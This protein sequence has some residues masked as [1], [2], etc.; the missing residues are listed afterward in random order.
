M[1]FL[2]PWP[3]RDQE[4]PEIGS[5][6]LRVLPPLNRQAKLLS[7]GVPKRRIGPV[8][9][10]VR[11]HQKTQGGQP[12]PHDPRMMPDR[13]GPN[14]HPLRTESVTDQAADRGGDALSTSA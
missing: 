6:R 3:D 12:H 2:P 13:G 14:P 9:P 5:G 8:E 11:P 10:L 4:P 7:Y 1:H